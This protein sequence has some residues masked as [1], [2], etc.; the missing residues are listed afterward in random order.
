MTIL[1]VIDVISEEV[2]YKTGILLTKADMYRLTAGTEMA[3][4]RAV[5]KNPLDQ[6]IGVRSELIEDFVRVLRMRVGNLPDAEP[7]GLI[8]AR[9]LRG[10][11]DK[12]VDP[13]PLIAALRE[14]VESDKYKS[15]GELAALEIADRSKLPMQTVQRF[16]GAVHENM[17]R[18]LT[19]FSRAK[20][21]SSWSGSVPLSKL[22]KAEHI[23]D[24][25]ETYLDQRFIDFLAANE[26]LL[27][28]MHWRNFERLTAEFFKRMEYEVHL[29][30]GSSDGGID[31]RVWPLNSSHE[32]PPLLIIQCKRFGKGRQVK[33]E[34][35]KA[36]WTDVV[37]EGAA[38]GLIATTASV[39]PAGKK[40]TEVRGY[41]LSFAENETISKWAKSMWRFSWR[42]KSKKSAFVG[43]YLL[44]PVY[45]G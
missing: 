7:G 41:P 1:R 30:P 31:V 34:V 32:N 11:T 20:R 24:D 43:K 39:S 5:L 33:V 10:M 9:F 42:G 40:V 8:M 2:A 3:D 4:W 17:D 12:G 13:A 28:K 29:G 37:F 45:F 6:K 18:N 23:P 19:L 38:G 26:N 27:D 21:S 25:P 15:I 22:F 16:L 35:V 36:F 14:V 44:P